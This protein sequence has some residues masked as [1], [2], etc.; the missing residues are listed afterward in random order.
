MRLA[1]TR[2]L[3]IRVLDDALLYQSSQGQENKATKLGGPTK[4]K[5]RRRGTRRA[6]AFQCL[7]ASEK[8]A[9]TEAPELEKPPTYAQREV[10]TP[11]HTHREADED[12]CLQH[13]AQR[14][15]NANS[16]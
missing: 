4:L 7:R 5:Q 8:G 1:F 9:E 11:P 12:I 15:D 6:S 10:D 13:R 2:T 16:Q 14:K 3:Q